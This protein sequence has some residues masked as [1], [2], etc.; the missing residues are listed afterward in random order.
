MN[1]EWRKLAR[2]SIHSRA[3]DRQRFYCTLKHMISKPSALSVLDRNWGTQSQRSS[4]R[5]QSKGYPD[6]VEQSLTKTPKY[7]VT[8]HQ[9]PKRNI[10]IYG[11]G[12]QNSVLTIQHF[13]LLWRQKRNDF[14]SAIQTTLRDSDAT[15][16][17]DSVLSSLGPTNENYILTPILS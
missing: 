8:L 1:T 6:N 3:S 10:K 16:V 4:D 5:L 17:Q 7:K 12:R 13:K 2:L 11:I 15:T 9:K 14:L